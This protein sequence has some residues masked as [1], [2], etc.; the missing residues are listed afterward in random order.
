MQSAASINGL[1]DGDQVAGV[2]AMVLGPWTMLSKF[3]TKLRELQSL[4]LSAFIGVQLGFA[5]VV[6][7]KN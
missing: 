2:A 6:S 7:E 1:E 3:K 4:T 5:F